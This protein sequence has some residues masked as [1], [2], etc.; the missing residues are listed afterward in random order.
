M[1]LSCFR[2]FGG[3]AMECVDYF[4]S[5]PLQCKQ[6]VLGEAM[7]VECVRYCNTRP[8]CVPC[9]RL[10]ASGL[11]RA[12]ELF[13]SVTGQWRALVAHKWV[14]RFA[15]TRALQLDPT[16]AFRTPICRW[17]ACDNDVP[18]AH[19]LDSFGLAIVDGVL[20]TLA[21]S[22]GVRGH[23]RIYAYKLITAPN[24]S[25]SLEQ[26]LVPSHFIGSA[27]LVAIV[28]DDAAGFLYVLE[29]VSRQNLAVHKI[30]ASAV[31]NSNNHN[32]FR[33]A[34][35][36]P[37]PEDI[38]DIHRQWHQCEDGVQLSP[39]GRVIVVHLSCD[40]CF[41]YKH[42]P[43]IV[44]DSTTGAVIFQ[45]EEYDRFDLFV[46]GVAK[47]HFFRWRRWN[48]DDEWNQW[49]NVKSVDWNAAK[50]FPPPAGLLYKTKQVGERI[51]SNQKRLA[52]WRNFEFLVHVRQEIFLLVSI[53]GLQCIDVVDFDKQRIRPLWRFNDWDAPN[54]FSLCVC[55][56]FTD[57]YG[58][59]FVVIK[60]G[61]RMPTFLQLII[62]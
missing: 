24:S 30:R 25:I 46:I 31:D 28:G 17:I 47:A 53:H 32:L 4:G 1:G 61:K 57:S 12:I 33:I 43:W 14:L 48:F 56:I 50:K 34:L 5:L 62:Q 49:K 7:A 38:F 16:I 3:T 51:W 60:N 55:T 54:P 13:G 27:A 8:E 20:Y 58:Q 35:R 23:A 19:L 42:Q 52:G 26:Q 39:D 29:R 9:D 10:V 40:Q 2:V 59:T 44:M 15:R 45:W 18:P 41:A 6:L 11:R 37:P 21:P 22:K 36:Y